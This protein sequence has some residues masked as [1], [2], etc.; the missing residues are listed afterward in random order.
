MRTVQITFSTYSDIGKRG[1]NE[2]SIGAWN[3]GEQHCFVLC[4]GLGGHAMGEDASAL[5]VEVFQNMFADDTKASEFLNDAFCAAQDILTAEQKAR[6]AEK[7]M[8]TT[9]AALVLD[10]SHAYIGHVG[11]SRVYAFSKNKVLK[12]TLDHSV[13]QM[14]ALTGEIKE[15]EIRFHPERNILLRVMGEKWESPMQELQ[16]PIPLRKCNAFLLCSD[17]FWELIEENEMVKLLQQSTSV[18]EWLT[19]MAAVVQ[20]KGIGKNTDNNSAIA[21]W[22]N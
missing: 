1:N 4:D 3:R 12:R 20:Q 17:G 19:K 15:S 16:K 13:P 5:V 18:S 21:I 14:L 8:R 7:Q 11:D 22:I 6:N 9:C 10:Q 2:D